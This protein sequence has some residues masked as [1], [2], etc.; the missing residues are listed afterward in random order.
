MFGHAWLVHASYQF[1]FVLDKLFGITKAGQRAG[2]RDFQNSFYARLEQRM[3]PM[4]RLRECELDRR[5][6]VARSSQSAV[7]ADDGSS[8]LPGVF[9]GGKLLGF[10]KVIRDMTERKAGEE[11][12]REGEER[13]R[14]LFDWFHCEV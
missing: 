7:S 3:H 1:D 14:T 5:R 4:L 2:A 9:D 11:A 12:L 8:G 6:G 13:Y 10:S